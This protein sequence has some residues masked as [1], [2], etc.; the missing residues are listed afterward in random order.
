[1]ARASPIPVPSWARDGAVHLPEPV[2]HGSS[3]FAGTPV[4]VSST[5]RT[6][7]VLLLDVERDPALFR[8]EF[9]GVGEQVQDDLLE[10]VGVDRQFDLVSGCWKKRRMFFWSA[11]TLTEE[12]MLS[13]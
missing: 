3:M 4:P 12:R 6:T 9:Q 8:G 13:M 5:V 2:E 10:L 11:R 7:V 1:M